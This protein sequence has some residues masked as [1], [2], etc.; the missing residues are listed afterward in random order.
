MTRLGDSS[1]DNEK[2][3]KNQID[4]LKKNITILET[5]LSDEQNRHAQE[6]SDL[7]ANLK[8]KLERLKEQQRRTISEFEDSKAQEVE[9]LRSR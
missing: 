9:V 5:S 6:M 1:G 2:I 4:A 7:T 8:D 3:L